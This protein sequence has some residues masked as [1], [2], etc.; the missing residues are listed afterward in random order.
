MVVKDG[1]NIYDLCILTGDVNNLFELLRLNNFSIDD[2]FVS[3]QEFTLPTITAIPEKY[4]VTTNYTATLKNYK[5]TTDNQNIFDVT[6]MY[7]GDI[8][9]LFTVLQ[10]N[11]MSVSDRLQSGTELLINNKNKGDERIKTRIIKEGWVFNNYQSQ[12]I[13]EVT[14][15]DYNNDYNNDYL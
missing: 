7:F 12:D 6:C 2:T 9:Y 14:L 1:Q 4:I 15:G 13:Q 8:S 5:Q 10:D 11:N 3:G